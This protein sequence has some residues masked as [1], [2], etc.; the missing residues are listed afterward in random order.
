M[1]FLCSF[2][3]LVFF[4]PC[5]QEEGPEEIKEEK[6]EVMGRGWDGY[7]CKLQTLWLQLVHSCHK[8]ACNEGII[9][10]FCPILC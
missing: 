5:N 2:L 7:R 1:N 10:F 4:F 8:C 3:H 6:E 9:F